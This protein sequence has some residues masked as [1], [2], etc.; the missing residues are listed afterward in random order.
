MPSCKMV[1][2]S[3]GYPG[4]GSP[5]KNIAPTVAKVKSKKKLDSS[6]SS[7]TVP[8][9]S[10]KT[11]PGPGISLPVVNPQVEGKAELRTPVDIPP[12]VPVK[13]KK[14]KLSTDPAPAV[15]GSGSV[16]TEP[17]LEQKIKKDLDDY[18]RLYSE[19]LKKKLDFMSRNPLPST[20]Q[21]SAKAY[22]KRKNITEEKDTDPPEGGG[23]QSVKSEMFSAWKSVAI[24]NWHSAMWV[25]FLLFLF[26]HF[27]EPSPVF[28]IS[29][30]VI[31]TSIWHKQFETCKEVIGS[32]SA[33]FQGVWELFL[34]N[35]FKNRFPTSH[36]TVTEI[37]EERVNFAKNDEFY[38]KG[39][40]THENVQ[41]AGASQYNYKVKIRVNDDSFVVAEIDTDSHICLINEEYFLK[42]AE[43]GDIEY[44]PE[45]PSTFNGLASTVVSKYSPVMLN[46]QIG[47]S[48]FKNRFNVTETLKSSP[49][50]LGTDFLIKNNISVSPY[51]KDEWF[52][53]IGPLNEPISKVPAFITNKIILCTAEN[54]KFAPFEIKKISVQE[55]ISGFQRELFKEHGCHKIL[56]KNPDIEIFSPFRIVD[57]ERC[58]DGA[59][60]VEN[61]SPNVAVLPAGMDL[62]AS[63][64]D[65]SVYKVQPLPPKIETCELINDGGDGAV[66]ST[67]ELEELLEPG[68][69][70]PT[71]I[72]KESELN[73]VRQHSKIPERFK[74][75]FVQ[76]LDKR[77]E[78]FSG[79]EFSSKHFPKDKYMH[80]VELIDPNTHSMNSRPFPCS[81]IRLQQLKSDIDDLVKN[82]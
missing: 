50:L 14:S 1:R 69:S 82:G 62:A 75:D 37:A 43:A 46:I 3:S 27:F 39:V 54:S 10:G 47:R 67:D 32:F 23:N 26:V 58:E 25:V 12:Q 24:E 9:Q 20:P 76:F 52:V 42:L 68:F 57:D 64:L 66:C 22:W 78:H 29:V 4:V 34:Q 79:E 38:D 16:L 55:N 41:E 71:L 74:E 13:K 5:S 73:F 49:V 35:F 59:I 44:L 48:I 65:L 28:L 18:N 45:P 2:N 60:L 51:N 7:G 6:L 72:D 8:G 53:T 19:E 21:F 33:F 56:F 63:N 15:S 11:V 77:S 80:D 61:K 40:V 17:T 30:L 36:K 70:S 81:G 31:T